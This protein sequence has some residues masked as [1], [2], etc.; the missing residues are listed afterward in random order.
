MKMIGD[1]LTS[2]ILFEALKSEFPDAELHYLIYKHTRPVIENNPF[3]DKLIIFDPG[4]HKSAKGL[5][6]MIHTVKAEKFDVVID[7]Y[8]KI[9]S[10]AISMRSGASEKISFK[11]WYTKNAYS[12]RFRPLIK[13]ETEAGLAIENR[14]LLL[15]GINKKFPKALK[16]KLY[17]T[18]KEKEKAKMVLTDHGIDFNQTLYMI[19]ILG[20]SES[21]SYP[22]PYMAM[23]LNYIVAQT[24]AQLIINFIPSQKESVLEILELCEPQTRAHVNLSIYGKDLREFMALTSFCTA[25]IGNEGGAVN[26]AKAL[27]VP[28]FSIF[29]PQINKA[30]WSL[31]DDG[32]KNVGV[33]L[34]D[35][36]PELFIEKDKKDL[37]KEAY[38][39]YWIFKPDFIYPDL[40][41]FLD[42]NH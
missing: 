10:A 22:K 7:V 19:G 34:N 6:H 30:D 20:S 26:M 38:Q 9:N 21:K 11:K 18:S 36:R 42:R 40:K 32:I 3:I 8:S 15:S 14:M 41:L 17:L 31:Y 35:Y 5:I 39:W 2:S 16:P 13:S 24:H 4:L 25:L 37:K 29:S 28:T 33:H 12:K 23:I 1:V 27:D